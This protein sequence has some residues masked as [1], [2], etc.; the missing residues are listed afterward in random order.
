[1]KSLRKWRLFGLPHQAWRN[2]RGRKRP[3]LTHNAGESSAPIDAE[4]MAIVPLR[5]TVADEEAAGHSGQG[6]LASC[7][8]TTE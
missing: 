8:V 7:N 6:C 4:T 1:M 2:D 3:T 5:K